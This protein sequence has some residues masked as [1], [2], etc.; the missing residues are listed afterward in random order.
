MR[1]K[2]GLLFSLLRR[3]GGGSAPNRRPAR[4]ADRPRR[5]GAQPTTEKRPRPVVLSGQYPE[6]AQRIT[7]RGHSEGAQT[8]TLH[9]RLPHSPPS[10]PCGRVALPPQGAPRLGAAEGSG[11]PERRVSRP[12]RGRAVPR[13]P[14]APAALHRPWSW[15]RRTC[16]VRQALA[17]RPQIPRQPLRPPGCVSNS[18]F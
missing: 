18:S 11:R 9:P 6:T 12:R 10:L 1:L 2:R 14:D 8:K 3:W 13:E 7:R 4:A 5:P 16:S 15:A 17:W